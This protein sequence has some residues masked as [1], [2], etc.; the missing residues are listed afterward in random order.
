MQTEWTV[1]EGG[2]GQWY[3]G[4][5]VALYPGGGAAVE[6]DDG[7][8]WT[9]ARLHR[10]YPRPTTSRHRPRHARERHLTITAA[11]TLSSETTNYSNSAHLRHH[12][13]CA[14]RGWPPPSSDG[15]GSLSSVYTL[16]GESDDEERGLGGLRGLPV[17]AP[18]AAHGGGAGA[19]PG[20]QVAVPVAQIPT[21][22]GVPV[23]AASRCGLPQAVARPV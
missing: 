2:D 22:V 1:E 5:V 9:G 8:L 20:V 16:R 19:Y 3:A 10:H 17:A 18:V 23:A 21:T 13:V 4:T 15:A 11:T 6:H 7:E 14:D 12:G